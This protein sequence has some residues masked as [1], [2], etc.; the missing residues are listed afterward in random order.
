MSPLGFTGS[1]SSAREFQVERICL[2]KFRCFL[3][4]CKM[5]NKCGVVNCTG[6]YTG[7]KC[8]VFRLPKDQCERQKWL[9]VLPPRE[10]FVINPRTFFIC[11]KHWEADPPLV[12]L[13]GGSTRPAIPPSVFNVPSS[14][15]PT[16][17]PAPRPAK[18]ED[19]QLEYFLQKDTIS[20]FETFNPEK[21]L[22]K[23]YGNVIV[24][25][26]EDR[27]VCLFMSENYTE[28]RVSV[29]VE[30]KPT[31]CSPLT[32]CAFKDGLSVPLGKILNPNNGLGSNSQFL[33]AVR[34]AVNFDP[35][36]EQVLNKLVGVLQECSNNCSDNKK[37]RKLTFLS[38]QLELL[39]QKN[40]SMQ[41]Y[42]F[43]VESFPKCSYEQL[44][45]Y[46]VLPSKRKLQC[47]VA[48]VNKE[49]VLKKTFQNMQKPQQRNVFL[50]VDEVQIR[51]TVAFSGGILSGMAQNNPDSRATHMLAVM[52]K[53]L[54]KGPSLMISITP[55]HKLKA[56][57]QKV[58]V[59]E[60]AAVVERSGGRV[61]GSITD[62]HKV[63]QHYCKLFEH[64]GGCSAIATHPLD[65]R[66][67]W[68]LLFDTVHLL[69]CIRNNW[70]SEKCQRLSL[71]SN[72]TASFADV[73][74]LY[75]E[76]K[77]SILKTTRLTQAAVNP[78]RL[79]LQNVQH[80]LRVFNDKVVAA[81]TLRG[82]L[83]TAN[84]VQTILH[85]WNI[86]NVSGKG[87]DQRMNDPN[88][89]VQYPETTNLQTYLAIFKNA[90]SGQ[91]ARRI[92]CLTHDTKKALVQTM[93]GL[94]AVCHHLHRNA[95][96]EYVLLRE[97][98]SDRLEGEFSVYRQSTGGNSFM[99]S[100]DVFAACKQ[101]LAR[102][103]ASYLQS[104]EV[105]PEPKQ[106][107]CMEDA[108]TLEDAASIETCITT[109]TLTV[110]E[111]SCAAYV[112][113]WLEMKCVRELAFSEEEPL[114]TSDAKDFI[115]TVSRGSLTT[116]HL[117]T[118][119]L[120]RGGLCFVKKVRHRAC[121]RRRLV[122]IL[123]TM[124]K[125]TDINIDCPKLFRHLANVLLNGIHNLEK[126]HQ[127][128]AVLLQ[129][130]VKKAR[131]AD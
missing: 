46:L 29:T 108:I 131:L 114:L 83:E 39:C 64:P 100:G 57:F 88:R 109:V 113:G 77:D 53:S 47:I 54:H 18:K 94:V 85:W 106:H 97:I 43:A 55:V 15:L 33:E 27:L 75:D 16:P 102:Y 8:R 122:E 105:Q 26:S 34:V 36:L 68:F 90:P 70:I 92:Q 59:T 63:N 10:N 82:C 120:V 76:E 89:C 5:P 4:V 49:E 129:T 30:R 48:N 58:V 31:L 17:K 40:F 118:F 3:S 69:K 56:D 14:C 44:R 72:T 19:Q 78:S 25:R 84:F 21:E 38:R 121:C 86:V 74:R 62:N 99:T 112:A 7:N 96:F 124:A 115:D 9:D 103:A 98:Q 91:G 66:R 41:D 80:V 51:P 127:K 126:D 81:L 116:P 22:K 95:D 67:V 107:T 42:C 1:R 12:K 111:E 11:E 125:F 37:E 23:L 2:Q 61:V 20:S 28:C 110:N 52:S 24:S 123:S 79:Q 35:P 73:K 32:L 6:N 50:L 60:A 117:A 128:N 45:D 93:E 130:S 119:D 13:P 65:N 71:D 104:L 101:R 87:Q